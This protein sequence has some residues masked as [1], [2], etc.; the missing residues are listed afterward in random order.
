MLLLAGCSFR[1]HEAPGDGAVD[2]PDAES[3]DAPEAIPALVQQAI[4][5]ADRSDNP[6]T[7]TLPAAPRAGDLLVM[8]GADSRGALASVTGGGVATWTRATRS[9]A[10]VNIEIWYGIS[11]GSSAA[12]TITYPAFNDPLWQ[13]VT[14]WSGMAA[15]NVFDAASAMSG[16]ASPA[17]AG[18]AALT[19]REL[20]VFGVADLTPNTFGAPS[21]GT[22]TA[23]MPVSSS[24]T[25][26]QAWFLVAQS[27]GS[28]APAVSETDHSWDAAIA[29]FHAAP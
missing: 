29:S 16:T 2:T 20:A 10:N 15:T 17:S 11:D 8:V 7:A 21:D 5:S 4:A 18:G 13:V 19:R 3:R 26:Q 6:L 1:L 27:A 9:L 23:L 14:E 25:V 22:W 12:V 28:V 24:S